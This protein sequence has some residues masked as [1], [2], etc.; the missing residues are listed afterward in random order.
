MLYDK[1]LEM[2]RKEIHDSR[3]IYISI[4]I[5][6]YII[7]YL[8]IIYIIYCIIYML[9]GLKGKEGE[10]CKDISFSCEAQKRRELQERKLRDEPLAENTFLPRLSVLSVSNVALRH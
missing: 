2:A 9:K 6:C 10:L 4:Y 1:R 7:Y 3:F 8:N 5:L